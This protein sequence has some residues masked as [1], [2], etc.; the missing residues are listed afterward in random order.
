MNT[1]MKRDLR[2]LAEQASQRGWAVAPTR[3][4]HYRWTHQSGAIVHSG[5]TLSDHRAI[6]N[7]AAM[8][9]RAERQ[10]VAV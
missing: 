1:N 9:R 4:G 7:I 3:N 10:A 8:L 5:S 2:D 6:K